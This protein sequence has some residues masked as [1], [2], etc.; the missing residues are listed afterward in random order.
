MTDKSNDQGKKNGFFRDPKTYIVACMAVALIAII[1]VTAL[2]I[3][4]CNIGTPAGPTAEPK[5]EEESGVIFYGFPEK[6]DYSSYLPLNV[7]ESILKQYNGLAFQLDKTTV[8]ANGEFKDITEKLGDRTLCTYGD[9]VMGVHADV[10]SDVTGVDCGTGYV[11]LDNIALRLNKDAFLYENKLCVLLDKGSGLDVFDDYYTFEMISLRLRNAPQEDFDNALM[12]LPDTVT[13]GEGYT[14]K[15]TDS[16]LELGLSTELYSLQGYG[17][18]VEQNK[19]MP[20][21]VAGE[22]RFDNNHTLVRVYNRYSAKI[23]QF[24][25]YSADVPGGV[26][27]AASKVDDRVVIATAA[28]NGSYPE[29]KSVKVFDRNGILYMVVT[30]DFKD[31]A[32]YLI[33]SGDF[34]GTGEEKLLVMAETADKEGNL[35][36]AI[37]SFRNGEVICKGNVAVG[38]SGAEH[39]FELTAGTGNGV[40]LNDRVNYKVYRAAF[41]KEGKTFDLTEKNLNIDATAL[42][43]SQSAFS[44]DGMVISIAR[45]VVD[46]NDRSYVR[47]VAD[48]GDAYGTKV[49]VGVYENI[50]YWY[51]VDS[52]K[53]LSAVKN[54]DLSD[55]DYVKSAAFQHIRTDLGAKVMGSLTARKLLTLAEVP[56]SEWRST[57]K[58]RNFSKTYNVWEPCFTHRFN[59]ISATQVLAK[60]EDENGF[61]RYLGYTNDNQTANYVEL[62]SQFYNATYAEGI[63]EL[64]K[65]RIYPLRTALQDIYSNYT[66]TPERLVG[67]EPIHE[68]EINVGETF[69][70]YNPNNIEGFR[71]YLLERFGSVENINKKFGTSFATRADIDAPRNGALGERGKWDKFEG[72]FF[73]QWALFTRKI[74][75]K[76]LTEAFREALLAGFPSEIISGHS[77]P[78]GDAISGFLGQTDTRM[79]PV[80]A[81]MTLGCHFGATRY[82]M[83]FQD[84]ANFLNLAYK[85]GFKNITMGE[86]NSMTAYSTRLPQRQLE[87]VWEH[88]SKYINILNISDSGTAADIQSVSELIKKND[89]RPG[90]AGGTGAS[91]AVDTGEK[92]YQLVELG[93][94]E[95]GLLKSVDEEGHWTGDVY[96]VPFH[97]HILVENLVLT[98]ETRA[99]TISPVIGD[100]QTG[101]VIEFNFLGTYKGSGNAK[102]VVEFFEDD[103]KN[104]RLSTEFVFGAEEK[105]IKYVLSNQVPLGAVKI[106]ISYV[107]EDY[108]AIEI[109]DISLAVERETIARKYFGDL[110]AT[111]HEGGFTF[112]VACV[113]KLYQ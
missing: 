43:V 111:A 90:Y 34:D 15:Y 9:K 41:N 57:A 62:D 46:D 104:E 58:I 96:L 31:M 95:T 60:Y 108:S 49:D 74:V 17:T 25:A 100:L 87:Y 86:Y 91:L 28:F 53:K 61:H 99:G 65:M 21:I 19:V 29:T 54:L 82:G 80:D 78:E 81:M 26:R 98:K 56:Y 18:G 30:P 105:P 33:L 24:L 52:N 109:K 6:I 42:N 3:G 89:P 64:D 40:I 59:I 79:S 51:T 75:N 77:I 11:V 97:S 47:I 44:E 10:L 13:N 1:S 113:E 110:E 20:V 12:N 5:K 107:C 38:T 4:G 14:V 50:F 27:V 88:G 35:P 16:D 7:A 68:I 92:Q 67:L 66:I 8:Y 85:A 102:V 103:V 22:G 55:T 106:K 37:Y 101:D 84:D 39:P 70:D 94:E 48:A 23:A 73:K 36:F 93:N 63:I 69:G 45:P 2:L 32:P 112:D 71:S 72:D 83:W 76:R